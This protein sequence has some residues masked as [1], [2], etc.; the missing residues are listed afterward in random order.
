MGYKARTGTVGRS[1]IVDAARLYAVLD[2][3]STVHYPNVS[4]SE[5]SGDTD[6]GSYYYDPAT[7]DR[8]ELSW[9][10]TAVVGAA[11]DHES[12]RSEWNLD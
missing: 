9:T 7:G 10:P 5:W 3:L 8:F 4:T 1:E 2:A 12:E 6:T 11:F